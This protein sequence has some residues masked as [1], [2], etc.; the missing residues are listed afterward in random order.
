MLAEA[1]SLARDLVNTPPSDLH[2]EDLAETAEQ[3]GGEA[4]L[5]VEVLD[6]KALAEGGYGGILGVGQGSANPPRLVRIA[7]GHPEARPHASRS[8]ARAS[9]STPAA[10]RSSRR[11]R[12]SG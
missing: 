7:Y 3:V 2:P 11:P 1:V 10:C 12:W 9:R 6:E 8:S 5:P 4:G